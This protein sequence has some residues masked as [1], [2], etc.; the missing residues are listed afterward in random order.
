M[1]NEITVKKVT[2]DN[3]LEKVF[4]IRKKVFVEEQNCPAELEWAN[5]NEST[6]FLAIYNEIPC[7]AARWRRTDKGFKLERFAVLQTFRGRGVGAELV[8]A[9]L[10]DIPST[11]LPVY[12]NS[13]LSALE[14]YIPFGF[15][16][17]GEQFEEAG[18]MHQQMILA[19]GS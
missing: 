12:L 6:H 10:A 13:Q 3:D 18:I 19:S 5:E 9:V 14:F 15:R 11:K 1:A 7:G 4:L 16:S 17:V 2:A 8:R